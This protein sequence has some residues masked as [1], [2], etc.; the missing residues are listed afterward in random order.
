MI[1]FGHAAFENGG[2]RQGGGFGGFGGADFSDIF[3][4][5]LVILVVVDDQEIEVPIT[6][7]QI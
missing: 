2:G 7:A 3:E 6:E 4:I 1:T 5:F